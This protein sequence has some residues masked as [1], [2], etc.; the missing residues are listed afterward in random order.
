MFYFSTRD[1]S[2]TAKPSEAILNGIAADG[3]LNIPESFDSLKFDPRELQ[4][5]TNLEI[6][7]RILAEFFTDFTEEEIKDCV[8]NAYAGRF[9]N[10]DIAPLTAVGDDFVMELYHGPTCAFKDVALLVLPQLMTR[11]MKKN[12][13]KEKILIL[14][15]TSGDTGSAALNGFADVEGTEIIVFYPKT[16]IS[17]VQER[18]MTSCKGNNVH[19][20]AVKGNFDDA[21][22]GV[23]QIFA[24]V[25]DTIPG[26]RLSSA[27][28]INIGRLAPQIAYYFK[29]YKDLMAMGRITCGEAV[30]FVVPTGNFGDILAGYFAKK[31][32]L[33][34]AKL[35]CASN[36]NDV[37]TEF[38]TTGS[39]KSKRPFHV[40]N[41]PSM[42]ILVSSN[43][44]R[45]ICMVCGHEKTKEYMT[46]LAQTG[47]YTLTADELTAIRTEFE[48][49]CTDSTETLR[50]IRGVYEAHKYLIDTHTAVAWKVCQDRKQ[51]NDNGCVNVIL[52]TASPYKFS[53]SVLEALTGEAVADTGFELMDRLHDMTG[54]PIPAALEK[55]KL[56]EPVHNNVVDKELMNRYVTEKGSK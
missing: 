43:L 40:T 38:F 25:G 50:T 7:E 39:Y 5:M 31:M 24:N 46:Q 1:K 35:I 45:L 3:G 22:R 47:E 36:E 23:K 29:A 42:D 33:P 19:V 44:E 26:V 10:D 49:G 6:S 8:R 14:T 13:I 53:G 34:V 55:M 16:G 12:D 17:V 51:E 21:Q 2:I 15:A 27:N 32:G 28:S 30:N 52:S 54:V 20:C 41:S 4:G 37:L 56:T 18:Q 11:A 48:A 9:P